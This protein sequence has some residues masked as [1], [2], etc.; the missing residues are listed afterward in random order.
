MP[1][2]IPKQDARGHGQT[3]CEELRNRQ[4]PVSGGVV[5]K[6]IHAESQRTAEADI[7]KQ[8]RPRLA[9]ASVEQYEEWKQCQTAN[10]LI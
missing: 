10:P 1:C 3:E 5:P 9:G 4:M 7:P 2:T 8:R 6:Y